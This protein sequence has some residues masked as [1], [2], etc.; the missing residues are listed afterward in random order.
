MIIWRRA[1]GAFHGRRRE[2]ASTIIVA[3]GRSPFRRVECQRPACSEIGCFRAELAV[4]GDLAA[5]VAEEFYGAV[6]CAVE[7]ISTVYPFV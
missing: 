3:S 1:H 2:H 7:H 4:D 6:D 5:E